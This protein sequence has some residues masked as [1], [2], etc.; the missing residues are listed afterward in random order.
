[1]KVSG[2]RLDLKNCYAEPAAQSLQDVLDDSS[3][4]HNGWY[5]VR[6]PNTGSDN[7]ATINLDNVRG[8][9]SERGAI[10]IG[11]IEPSKVEI[12][13]D[14]ISFENL[15]SLDK[16]VGNIKELSDGVLENIDVNRLSIHNSNG[17]CFSAPDASGTVEEVC[18]DIPIGDS[19]SITIDNDDDSADPF[20]PDVPTRDEVGFDARTDD[21]DDGATE[22]EDVDSPL[23]DVVHAWRFDEGDGST[24]VDA[25]GSA[26]G[27]ITGAD[28][29]S[30]DW[31]GESALGFT[32]GDYVRVGDDQAALGEEG[33]LVLTA[34]GTYT[35]TGSHR[36]YAFAHPDY[37]NNNRLYIK[38]D[39][40]D[41]DD[42]WVARVGD[43]PQVP[44]GDIAPDRPLRL[45]VTWKDGAITTYRDGEPQHTDSYSGSLELNRLGWLFGAF[46]NDNISQHFGG[47]L[48]NVL[49]ADTAATE[50]QLEEDFKTQPWVEG[51]DGETSLF[52]DW[53]PQWDGS[54]DDW[55]VVSGSEFE[56]G[57]ALAFDHD[58]D[59]QT[60]R[61][62]S[63]DSV[64]TP[65]DVEVL[66]KFRTP[67]LFSDSPG[68]RAQVQ[69]RAS[70]TSG[71]ENGYWLGVDGDEGSFQVG[72][73]VDGG[74]T[75]L[76]QFGTPTEG[77]F[78]YRRFR[79][80]GTELKAKAW[81]VGE[82]EPSGWDVELEVE[83]H[84]DG[85]VGLGSD[86]EGAVETDV[87]SVAT[88]GESA[89]FDGSESP[90][91]VAWEAPTDGQTVEGT[92]TIRVDASDD[93]ESAGSLAVEY[94]V[95]GRSWSSTA[96]DQESG[97]YEDDWDSSAVT[98]G[99]HTLEARAVDSWG[100]TATATAEITVE[101]GVAVETIDASG[102][103]SSS[104]TLT[105]EITSLDAT[106]EATVGF[107]WRELEAL[108]WRTTDER[109]VD[110]TGEFSVDLSGLDSDT[111][112][113]Y[114]ALAETD[115]GTDTGE[116]RRFTTEKMVPPQV[117]SLDFED[118]SDDSQSRFEIDWAVSHG[119]FGLDTV[120]TELLYNG[121]AVASENSRV[122]G[123]AADGTHELE[124][125]GDVEEIRLLVNDTDN[126]VSSETREL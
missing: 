35:D 78:Y 54:R 100:N 32:E 113:E 6:A 51:G 57:H 63:C 103:S 117:E 122:S 73:Y 94:R 29:T 15:N 21:G 34:R 2:G 44:I 28:W 19:G 53:T 83:G 114:R 58:G 1:M 17:D 70:G 43:S 61:A 76:G 81:P 14:M 86:D 38:A 84:T 5:V 33:T 30:G 4:S 105:G 82:V 40:S 115:E 125:Q 92:A 27:E 116:I 120:I 75:T 9:N 104:A 3:E 42:Q 12:T 77:E 112:Y 88:G 111:E 46:E 56:G 36:G 109:T 69:V 80:E 71:N 13:G 85:W 11:G 89:Q 121:W 96:Y 62:V 16:S 18:H 91:T 90:P 74:T 48:D 39:D 59:V 24:V 102:V 20:S 108:L 93:A 87:F 7:T 101:N 126:Q 97:Y 98:D 55:R 41:A 118:R 60:C 110:S 47:E 49:L 99:T 37:S 10:Q 124:V 66:D 106:G 23:P 22:V 79:T 50:T 67:E 72:T 123:T 65:S 31:T 26:D 68:S 64:G 8:I 119:D 45:A 25:A 52:D 95:D 107:E